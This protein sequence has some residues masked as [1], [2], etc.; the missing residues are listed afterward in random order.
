MTIY[1]SIISITST[2]IIHYQ[3]QTY[4]C[5]FSFLNANRLTKHCRVTTQLWERC[6]DEQPAAFLSFSS[7]QPSAATTTERSHGLC[8][9]LTHSSRRTEQTDRL[10]EDRETAE[11]Q[12]D[13]KTE[14]TDSATLGR[15]KHVRFS[16][17]RTSLNEHRARAPRPSAVCRSRLF[18]STITSCHA[19]AS[20]DPVVVLSIA[21][22]PHEVC[23]TPQSPLPN[24]DQ[25]R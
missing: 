25:L 19:H 6:V 11:R 1:H 20:A 10:T 8:H 7:S 18:S 13:R 17:S 16:G 14:K 5:L 12:K 3:H 22:I 9:S 2:S 23:H 21:V 15:P 24:S 4:L